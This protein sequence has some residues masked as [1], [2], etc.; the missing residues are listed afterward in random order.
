M[1]L[2]ARFSGGPPGDHFRVALIRAGSD[3]HVPCLL[4]RAAQT[5]RDIY[6]TKRPAGKRVRNGVEVQHRLQGRRR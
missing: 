2:A 4:F 3:N 1:G 5:G 6:G